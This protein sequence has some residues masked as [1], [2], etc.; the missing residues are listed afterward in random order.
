M[1]NQKSN[2]PVADE[3][4]EPVRKTT[5]AES[6]LR[7]EVEELR[8]A[9]VWLWR[10]LEPRLPLGD[11][12]R[13]VLEA[14]LGATNWLDFE[15]APEAAHQQAWGA[16]LRHL[17]TAKA[18]YEGQPEALRREWLNGWPPGMPTPGR[19]EVLAEL[20]GLPVVRVLDISS[21]SDGKVWGM[22]FVP[23][24][25]Q[26]DVTVQILEGTTKV[27]ALTQ[28]RN[29]LEWLDRDWDDALQA[30]DLEIPF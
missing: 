7:D 22:H 6:R 29:V 30:R 27:E 24:R 5:A 17:Q 18:A 23:D 14:A 26:A 16:A 13:V 20:R 2:A 8:R 21:S 1:I 10:R 19:E 9:V 25:H 15:H 11:P 4:P 3:G 12:L 28:L